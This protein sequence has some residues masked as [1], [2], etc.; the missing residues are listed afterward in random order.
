MTNGDRIRSMTDHELAAS[1]MLTC[2]QC[3][4]D[5][6]VR[7]DRWAC[8]RLGWDCVRGKIKWL[9]QEEVR[10]ETQME[11]QKRSRAGQACL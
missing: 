2:R 4:Y 11:N 10:S 5:R 9:E 1:R 3:I 7:S 8:V 6:F